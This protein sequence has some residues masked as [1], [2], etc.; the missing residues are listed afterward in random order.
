MRRWHW[1]IVGA[2]LIATACGGEV[3]GGNVMAACRGVHIGDAVEPTFQLTGAL[4]QTVRVRRMTSRDICAMY[5][6]P[7]SIRIEL[8]GRQ[9][10]SYGPGTGSLYVGPT[11]GLKNGRF[12]FRHRAGTVTIAGTDVISIAFKH[13]RHF[14]QPIGG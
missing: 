3:S 10:W 9:V 2:A 7:Q 12:R 11:V 13:D 4:V 5:G 14:E 1:V 8:D 6:E